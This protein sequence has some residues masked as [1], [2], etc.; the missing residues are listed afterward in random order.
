MVV[1]EASVSTALDYILV[2]WIQHRPGTVGRGFNDRTPGPGDLYRPSRQYDDINGALDEDI[3]HERMKVVDF[4]IWQMGEKHR[5]ALTDH[6]RSLMLGIPLLWPNATK[7]M[8]LP[9]ASK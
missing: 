5:W 2:R 7:P 1:A 8:R 3:E 4:Q 6:A 9:L